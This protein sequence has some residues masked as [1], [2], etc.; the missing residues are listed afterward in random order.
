MR[1]GFIWTVNLY[2]TPAHRGEIVAFSHEKTPGL[3]LTVNLHVT[4][5]N[6]GE[7][8]VFFMKNARG[9]KITCHSRPPH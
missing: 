2:A 3:H 8:V 7:I 1:M 5:A 9:C 4:P 6:R